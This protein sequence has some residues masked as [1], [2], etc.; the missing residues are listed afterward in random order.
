MLVIIDRFE[1]DFAIVELPSKA[2]ANLPRILVPREA[3]EGDVVRIE[4]DAAETDKR[5]TRIAA[6]MADVWEK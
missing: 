1:G 3:A 6:L 2:T 4:I 5:R